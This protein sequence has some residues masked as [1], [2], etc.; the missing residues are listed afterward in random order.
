[1]AEQFQVA[2]DK[3]MEYI[4]SNGA[5]AIKLGK[6]LVIEEFGLPRDKQSF[7][8]SAATSFRDTYFEKILKQV[9]TKPYIAGANFWTFGG[10]ARPLKGQLFW[11][12]GDEYM[13]DPPMEEQGL[14]S[15]FDS[16]RSTWKIVKEHSRRVRSGN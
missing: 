15:I 12:S 6:P 7:E 8:I 16:D 1:M 14:Y 5:V 9:R 10:K 3:S 11:K 4:D 13:G 2:V